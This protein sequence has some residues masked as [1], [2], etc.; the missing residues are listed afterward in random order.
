[1]SVCWISCLV[2]V[3]W[4]NLVFFFL[5]HFYC[6]LNVYLFIL[7]KLKTIFER[8]RLFLW[9]ARDTKK[10]HNNSN[11]SIQKKNFKLE[12]IINN[13]KK[14]HVWVGMLILEFYEIVM[15]FYCFPSIILIFIKPKFLNIPLILFLTP[16]VAQAQMVD[17]LELEGFKVLYFFNLSYLLSKHNKFSILSLLYLSLHYSVFIDFFSLQ[18]SYFL[19][20]HIFLTIVFSNDYILSI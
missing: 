6:Y 16:S 17:L 19:N 9:V 2:V 18:W 7:L 5:A 15:R 12:I 10:F 13:N 1:M 3:V 14:A 4:T 8:P 11:I 20:S